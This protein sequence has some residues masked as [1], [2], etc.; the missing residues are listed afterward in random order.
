M[1]KIG[2]YAT[3]RVWYKYISVIATNF[4]LGLPILVVL[5][6]KMR[7]LLKDLPTTQVTQSVIS[8]IISLHLWPKSRNGKRIG[9]A[10]TV[11]IF[12]LFATPSPFIIAS[13]VPTTHW[14]STEWNNT[15]SYHT[16]ASKTGDRLQIASISLLL[17]GS[18]AFVS[19][20]C[21]LLFEDKWVAKIVA[22]FPK[23]ST[24]EDDLNEGPPVPELVIEPENIKSNNPRIEDGDA[25]FLKK[26]TND[27][28][29]VCK[30][31]NLGSDLRNETKAEQP[32][33]DK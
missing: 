17:V 25:D 19:V 32:N 14:T 27:S 21:L 12:F 26:D 31:D 3:N 8:D 23:H 5:F 15:G 18:L 11:F 10:M 13:P 33:Q 7:S 28:D 29:L 9:L 24:P 1:V 20:T 16:W 2:A 22:K 30:E 6:L 4:I